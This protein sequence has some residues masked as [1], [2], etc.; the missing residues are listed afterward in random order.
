MTMCVADTCRCHACLLTLV[1]SRPFACAPVLLQVLTMLK[2]SAAAAAVGGVYALLFLLSGTLMAVGTAFTTALGL[3][4]FLSILAAVYLCCTLAAFVQI[5]RACSDPQELP[6]PLVSRQ[7]STAFARSACRVVSMSLKRPEA[8]PAAVCEPEAGPAA[9]VDAEAGRAGRCKEA[10]SRSG[11]VCAGAAG[12]EAGRKGVGGGCRE[13][14]EAAQPK[15]K[16]AACC[17]GPG[18]GSSAQQQVCR[19]SCPAVQDRRE[20]GK[21]EE[22]V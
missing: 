20:D 21:D 11:P 14:S 4:P 15:G 17:A 3:G 6:L 8:P 1:I 19:G 16:Q 7:G 18:P 9:A 10:G 12:S 5:I 22:V 13:L 2:Q